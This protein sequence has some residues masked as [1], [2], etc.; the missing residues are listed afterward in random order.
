MGFKSRFFVALLILNCSLVVFSQ[1]KEAP[2]LIIIAIDGLRWQEVYTGID[3]TVI[4]NNQSKSNLKNIEKLYPNRETLMPF[5]WKTFS[6]KAKLFG[7]RGINSNVEVSNPYW[8]SYPGYSEML[9]GF[10]DKKI[11]SNAFGDNPNPTILTLLQNRSAYHNKVVA[12]GAWSAFGRILD[13][14][15]STFPVFHS[16]K[17]YKNEKSTS[18]NLLN[19]MN[20]EAIKPWFNGECLDV[21]THNMAMDYLITQKPKVIFIGYGEVDEWAHAENYRYYLDAI[22]NT[23]HYLEEIWNFVQSTKEYQD[24]TI[25]LITTD[26]GRGTENQWSDH[27][28]DI[29]GSNQTWFALY[30]PNNKVT[31]E[32]GQDQTIYLQQLTPTI[33]HLLKQ[34]TLISTEMASPIKNIIQ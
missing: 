10:V 34:S 8:L 25:I 6:K 24:N 7:N 30:Q 12:F 18:A 14:K 27:G 31:G 9:S 29:I 28:N 33:L 15:N 16:F 32:V 21:F 3:S 26:H 2:N 22:K 4:K 19:K 23:D 11:N 20:Q 13:E 17:E 5:F 1:T